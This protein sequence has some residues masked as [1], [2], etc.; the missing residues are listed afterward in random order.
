MF[1]EKRSNTNRLLRV[2]FL[3]NRLDRAGAERVFVNQANFLHNGGH[4]VFFVTLRP[5]KKHTLINELLVPEPQ[6]LQVDYHGLFN[7]QSW[8]SLLGFIDRNKI[9]VI[10]STLNRSNVLSRV[11][12][13]LR[14]QLRVI[15]RESGMITDNR[16]RGRLSKSWKFLLADMV[17]NFWADN[18]VVLTEEMRLATLR[19]QP[20]HRR[21]VVIV[22]NG[23][24]PVESEEELL[25]RN[26]LKGQSRELSLLAAASMNYPE[27]AFEYLIRALALL[28]DELHKRTHL[29]FAGDGIMRPRY[30]E[31]VRRLNLTKQVTFLGRIGTAQ[32][33]D[34]YR[35]AHLFILTSTAEGFPNVLLEA[36]AFGLP[37]IT[38]K[39]GG[40]TEIVAEG[41]TG[42]FIP[43]RDAL[44]ITERLKWWHTNRETWPAMSLAAYRRMRENYSL[45]Q[46]MEKLLT[47]LTP[48]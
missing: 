33:Y 31:E 36:Q 34:E 32:L 41:K 8:S 43:M 39:V 13:M 9:E 30:E 35:R 48:S 42:F 15:I 14:P 11:L 18:I 47:V 12:K 17:L 23:L 38:T 16:G 4:E 20:W 2:L 19:Y 44:A 22:G 7:R 40:A 1:V 5:E 26:K 3:I 24:S 29:V 6:R 28:P 21:R 27:R 45:D 46:T 25:A 10:Y 37:V